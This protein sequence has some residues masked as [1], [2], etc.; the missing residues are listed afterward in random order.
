MVFHGFPMVFHRFPSFS[1]VFPWFSYAFRGF[2][3]T[4]LRAKPPSP[5]RTEVS[6]SDGRELSQ[7]GERHQCRLASLGPDRRLAAKGM[8]SMEKL[9]EVNQYTLIS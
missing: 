7:H 9:M 5:F 1:I 2:F 3:P 4:F 6:R 8:V